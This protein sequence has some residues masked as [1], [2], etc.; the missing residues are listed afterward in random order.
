MSIDLGPDGGSGAL[1]VLRALTL[2]DALGLGE[3]RESGAGR[4]ALDVGFAALP[5]P[6]I[7]PR[8]DLEK[9]FPILFSVRRGGHPQNGGSHEDK[10]L[11]P[12]PFAQTGQGLAVVC[13]PLLVGLGGE[14]R[15]G[16]LGFNE[17][18][19][20]VSLSRLGRLQVEKLEA[21][22][23]LKIGVERNEAATRGD[24][25]GRE[26]GIGPE[27]VPESG[28]GRKDSQFLFQ[29]RRFLKESHSRHLKI[30]AVHLPRPRGGQWRAG[31]PTLRH[32]SQK[33]EHR[34][35]TKNGQLSS[36][37]FPIVKRR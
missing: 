12:P 26:I 11:A 28:L 1:D 13:L 33:P 19:H 14:T 36:I 9:D 25:K 29:T 15:D 8:Q 17:G 34:D 24:G 32:Q 4:F 10:L 27:A 37:I 22:E 16:K 6:V 30:V 5:S 3:R 23:C 7:V 18:G 20:G 21:V 35:P 31:D 2:R